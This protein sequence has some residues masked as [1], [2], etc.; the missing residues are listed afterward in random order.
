LGEDESVLDKNETKNIAIIVL[1]IFLVFSCIV[2]VYY[3]VASQTNTSGKD[4][5]TYYRSHFPRYGVSSILDPNG[6]AVT[7]LHGE[8]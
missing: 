5:T 4:I 7:F 3:Y 6:E 8:V 1:T 2:S